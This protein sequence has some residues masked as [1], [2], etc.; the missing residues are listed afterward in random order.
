MKK[1]IFIS[2]YI[3]LFY[4]STLLYSQKSDPITNMEHMDK[5]IFQWGYYFGFNRMDFQFD[6]NNLDYENPFLKDIQVKKSFG[7]NIGITS[8]LRLVDYLDLRF[9]PGLF[10]NQRD[11]YF[12]GFDK[13]R[14][15]VRTT[16]ST[17]IYFPLLL[18]VSTKR[19]Y[20]FKP[21]VTGGVSTTINLSSGNNLSSDNYEG[22]FRMQKNSFFYEVGLGFDIYTPYFRMSP[23][24]RGIFSMRNELVRDN[25][26]N[27]PWTGN[28]ESI[29]TQGFLINLNF[30]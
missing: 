19:W 14:D 2:I 21:Y 5:R 11:L 7:F 13:K 28:I 17:Y 20:N 1:L 23:S 4:P 6:M 16:R 22:T 3:L 9:E 12:A 27:S 29:R 30:E 10:Y 25:N 24:I 8:N 15:Y 18:K 26:P